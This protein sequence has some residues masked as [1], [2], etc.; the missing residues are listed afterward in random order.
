MRSTRLAPTLAA[1]ALAV[2]VFAA[3][4]SA[5]DRIETK[6]G[7]VFEGEILSDDGTAVEIKTNEGA[8]MK[9]PIENLVPMSVYR[10]KRDKTPDDVDSQLDLADW[11]VDQTL[12]RQARIHFEAAAAKD[13]SRSDEINKR[14]VAARTKAGKD[15]LA[16]AK[17]LQA[18]N[19]NDDAR[20]VLKT[21]VREL[22]LE[23]VADEATEMLAGDNSRRKEKVMTRRT[24]KVDT[25]GRPPEGERETRASGEEFS[26][27]AY[28]VMSPS[29]DAYKKMLDK[30]HSGLTQKSQSSS[31]KDYEAAIKEG[32]KAQKA[33]DKVRPQ[34][35]ED[36]EIAE[37]IQL[38]EQHLE[39][40][41][42]D[43]RINLID[44]YLMRDSYNQASE[45]VNAGLAQYPKNDRL[46]RARERVTSAS[47]SN[48]GGRIF[49]RRR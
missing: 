44:A 17:S 27:N 19:R 16:Q 32:E 25:S 10:L 24:A 31:I 42:V 40:G 46:L 11:C 34:A 8:T 35:Q 41:V 22:P 15:L 6:S 4:V 2:G 39:E 48:D 29:I 30:N 47:S 3:P 38:V 14:L 5:Q 18:S 20:D 37:A 26:D 7:Q 12:Y 21:I 9:V 13:P 23:P 36:D 49:W 28:S 43:A 1:L 33:V 45:V